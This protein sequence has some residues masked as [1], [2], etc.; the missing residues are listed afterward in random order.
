MSF[1]SNASCETSEIADSERIRGA[2]RLTDIDIRGLE[3]L[4]QDIDTLS[5]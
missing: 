4:S 2:R 5:L 3:Q 1:E